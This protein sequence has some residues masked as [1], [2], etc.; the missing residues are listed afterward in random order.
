MIR[1]WTGVGITL[2]FD[3][4]LNTLPHGLDLNRIEHRVDLLT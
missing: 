1:A 4:I 2:C 3:E